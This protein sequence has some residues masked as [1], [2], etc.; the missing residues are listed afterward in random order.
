MSEG[1]EIHRESQTTDESIEILDSRSPKK[2]VDKS[3]DTQE[4]NAPI[5]TDPVHALEKKIDDSHID[6][7][8]E[9]EDVATANIVES[10][11]KELV[12]QSL[13]SQNENVLA[14]SLKNDI[15]PEELKQSAQN[16]DQSSL[17]ELTTPIMAALEEQRVVNT[18]SMHI[19][20]T[21]A[22]PQLQ[23][24]GLGAEI[25]V[26]SPS[27][28]QTLLKSSIE[29]SVDQ[30]KQES[31]SKT[32]SPR[33]KR[34]RKKPVALTFGQ[35]EPI[36]QKI[37]L[38]AVGDASLKQNSATDQSKPKK[39]RKRAAPKQAPSKKLAFVSTTL[40]SY[41]YTSSTVSTPTIDVASAAQ[42]PR[43]DPGQAPSA[44][45]STGVEPMVKKARKR[46]PKKKLEAS[47]P[48]IEQSGQSIAV[49]AAQNDSTPQAPA[50]LTSTD[51]NITSEEKPKRK[52]GPRKKKEAIN[53][54]LGAKL[55]VSKRI[56]GTAQTAT[57]VKAAE[58]TE[59][60]TAHVVLAENMTVPVVTADGT[61]LSEA[62]PKR[63]RGPRKKKEINSAE[64]AGVDLL[65]GSNQTNI[66]KSI[67][68]D[69]Q[70]IEKP[71]V[72]LVAP[73]GSITVQEKPKRKRAPRKKK[74]TLPTEGE[75]LSEGNQGTTGTEQAVDSAQASATQP[76]KPKRVR[77]KTIKLQDGKMQLSEVPARDEAQ[78]ATS[79]FTE[80]SNLETSHL[81]A[82][83]GEAPKPKRQRKTRAPKSADETAQTKLSFVSK[84]AD[85]ADVV[86]I[87][88]PPPKAIKKPAEPKLIPTNLPQSLR[89]MS[90]GGFFPDE[91]A[92]RP[93]VD[94]KEPAKA[95]AVQKIRINGFELYRG[96]RAIQSRIEALLEKVPPEERAASEPDNIDAM[97][98]VEYLRDL[99]HRFETRDFGDSLNFLSERFRWIGKL[100]WVAGERLNARKRWYHIMCNLPETLPAEDLQAFYDECRR[101]AA[102]G[103]G[104]KAPADAPEA[105]DPQDDGPIDG[106]DA[107]QNLESAQKATE[108]AREDIVAE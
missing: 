48:G 108:V 72:Y 98:A 74:E 60:A 40:F 25:R 3:P 17:S 29:T 96:L 73:D 46:T 21:S 51:G 5:R 57:D 52:R 16:A 83:S 8:H 33:P 19:D 49:S 15:L 86:S 67:V 14:E 24:T 53:G 47:E 11:D 35:E 92:E 58:H 89:V 69:V 6:M 87:E 55:E 42:N 30:A 63:K 93:K 36:P 59:K 12:E 18:S 76:E 70:L 61:V 10:N 44:D 34:Q 20:E 81:S 28:D 95:P 32:K 27:K 2:Q 107:D 91:F 23:D 9:S 77:K 102:K 41:G 38:N 50:V 4:E 71:I 100:Y 45:I 94:F 39:P 85:S 37:S 64:G 79:S 97:T 26:K 90:E 68:P 78:I 31:S 88:N 7:P 65:D 101:L 106:E 80:S 105:M 56:E 22:V 54:E 43:K 66:I 84:P 103:S 82:I 1:A 62:K 99:M 104:E 13:G 75:L